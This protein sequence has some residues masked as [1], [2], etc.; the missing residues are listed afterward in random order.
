MSSISSSEPVNI[1]LLLPPDDEPSPEVSILVPAL[2]EELTVG[3]FVDW[4]REGLAAAG[5]AGEV[6][7]VDSSHDDTPNIALEHG[8]RVLRVPRRGLGQRIPRDHPFRA[9]KIRHHGRR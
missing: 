1:E 8:A 4:C 9:G 5:V 3:E 7:I 6:L 2:N